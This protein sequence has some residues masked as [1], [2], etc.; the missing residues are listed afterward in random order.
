MIKLLLRIICLAHFVFKC[1]LKSIC[2]T[3]DIKKTRGT[4]QTV[5][6]RHRYTA[7]RMRELGRFML[8]AKDLDKTV[9]GLEHSC[10]PSKFPLTEFSPDKNEYGKPSTA[11]KIGFCLK[12]TVEVLIGQT[13]IDAED[14]GERK[15]KKFLEVLG[16]KSLKS[17]VSVSGHQTTQEKRWNKQDDN[18]SPN[19]S[20]L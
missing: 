8:A 15:A 4:V 7:Q 10:A 3:E 13:L 16:K 11:V 19:M 17:N 9:R 5:K 14:L 1:L 6:S 12:G 18:P 20:R 2:V